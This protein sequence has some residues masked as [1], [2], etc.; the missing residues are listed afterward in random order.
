MTKTV[1]EIEAIEEAITERDCM[2]CHHR[3]E[4]DGTMLHLDGRYMCA[5]AMECNNRI[6][7]AMYDSEEYMRYLSTYGGP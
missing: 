5:N 4:K 6:A 3:L 2:Y 1:K 7:N